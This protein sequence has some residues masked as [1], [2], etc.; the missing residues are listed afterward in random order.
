MM[1]CEAAV[2]LK[3]RGK[4]VVLVDIHGL[5]KL[6]SGMESRLRQWFLLTLWPKMGIPFYPYTKVEKVNEKG[7]IVRDQKWGGR[8]HLLEGETVVFGL[9][10]RVDT[11]LNSLLSSGIAEEI[12]RIGDCVRPRSILEAVHEGYRVAA[13]I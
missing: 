12:H 6:G 3:G 8:L 2:F 5:D 13:A 4:D 11:K 9:G 10:L 7:L 1:G